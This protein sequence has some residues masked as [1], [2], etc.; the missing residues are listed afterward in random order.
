M[1]DL[2]RI[3]DLYGKKGINFRDFGIE[4]N[5]NGSITS[6]NNKHI[7]PKTQELIK[8]L[9]SDVANYLNKWEIADNKIERISAI[10]LE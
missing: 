10:T 7:E 3:F 2:K 5:D 9:I 6:I 4:L 8:Q 1:V